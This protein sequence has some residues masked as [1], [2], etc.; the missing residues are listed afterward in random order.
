MD[1]VLKRR[2]IYKILKQTKYGKNTDNQGEFNSRRSV[3]PATLIATVATN[4][5]A[6]QQICIKSFS[7]AY[8]TSVG[9]IFAFLHQENGLIKE[10]A[11]WELKKLTWDQMA[12]KV[13][14]L[15]DKVVSF[16]GK[17]IIQEESIV[18]V[19]MPEMICES[20]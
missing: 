17:Y 1:K 12:K 7:L 8:G 13:E 3:C 9:T 4:V 18:T 15:Q 2:V 16:L 14:T 19:H 11:S 5:K 20:M 6:H 10:S